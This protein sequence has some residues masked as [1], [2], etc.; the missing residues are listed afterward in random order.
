MSAETGRGQ[1][2][3]RRK[4]ANAA[5]NYKRITK[6]ATQC[7][8]L[9]LS[10]PTEPVWRCPFLA[11]DRKWRFEAVRTVVDPTETLA[12]VLDALAK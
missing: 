9:A 5:P 3:A 8:L 11:V 10:G 4:S 7:P 6:K 12:I 2:L 1:P